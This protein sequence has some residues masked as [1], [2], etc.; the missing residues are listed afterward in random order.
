MTAPL[1]LS[2][3]RVTPPWWRKWRTFV[4]GAS[5]VTMATFTDALAEVYE[6]RSAFLLDKPIEAS[7]F[8]GNVLSYRDLNRFVRRAA[9]LLA[10]LGVR[11][12][13]RIALATSNRI[14]I[15]IVEFGAQRLGAVPV[16]INYMLTRD[17]IRQ[18]VERSGATV[19]VT[20]RSVFHGTLR[21][22]AALPSIAHWIMVTNQVTPAGV[23]SF[24]EL[25][26]AAGEDRTPALV[27]PDDPAVI[28]FTAGTTGLP[29]G[30][31]LTSG[32]LMNG[33]LRYARLAAFMPT[34]TSHLALLVM[35]L[36]HT[37]GHQNLLIQLAL[38][39]PCL[40]MGRFDPAA[41]LD[42]I[43]R[44][45]CTMFAGIPAMYRM[46][47]E[48][49]A[50]S[51]DLTSIRV[52]GGGGD[53]FPQELV[54]EFRRLTERRIGPF[55]RSAAFITGYG[56]AETAGQVS[57][58]ITPFLAGGDACVGFFLPGVKWRLV[59]ENGRDVA[60]GQ[61]GELWLKTSGLMKGYWEDAEGTAKAITPD[62]WFRTGDLLKR[63][64]RFRNHFV[65]R[66]KD[67]IKVGGYSVFPAEVERELASHPDIERCVV[68]GLPHPT[69]GELPVAAVIRRDGATATEDEILAWT[70]GRIAAYRRPRRVVFVD[71]IPENFAMKPL[72]RHVKNQLLEMGVVAESRGDRERQGTRG[73]AAHPSDL[74]AHP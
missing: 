22:T 50:R 34:S 14:E 64:N 17:E 51:R 62:G 54:N 12:G 18:L 41:I 16:P 32:G 69:K 52:W 13:D 20:D 27:A 40:V 23:H 15:A 5:A 46:L 45:R 4:T 73:G 19:M 49:G 11:H 47:L 53:A 67:M 3:I 8:T 26:S 58:S 63:G 6:D 56:L 7:W 31:V 21:D 35:P 68:V 71:G 29:K 25:M 48:A 44:Y 28:F 36:A 70:E 61:V 60:P 74:S 1:D 57:I 33:F 43:E 39:R 10:R 65:A 37:G 38:A 42:F 9:D 72:R 24:D 55:R 2:G 30:A 59:D 66:E